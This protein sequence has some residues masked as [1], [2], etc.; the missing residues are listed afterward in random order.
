MP[1][2]SDITPVILTLNEEANLERT[3]ASIAWA[4]RIVIVDSG[5]TD[6]TREIAA[7]DPRVR[8]HVRAFDTHA[9][10]WTF[11]T[12][13]PDINTTWILALDADYQTP[14]ET[15]AEIDAE[16]DRHEVAGYRLSFRYAVL[17]KIIGSGIY[18]PVTCLFRKGR[19]AYVQDGHT[20][21][22]EVQGEVR[23]LKS[24][25][26]HD[27]QKSF[28]RWAASQARYAS[29]ESAKLSEGNGG[30]KAWIRTHTPFAAFAI[31]LHCLVVRGGLF[32]GVPGWLYAM[33]RT[34]AEGLI[35]AAYLES[36][37]RNRRDRC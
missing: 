4:T 1:K 13:H 31:G 22:L 16:P 15:A 25:L 28:A 24:R 23:P 26:I 35:A 27:D 19:G 30:L 2:L 6:R 37:L 10:Q 3:L 14:K 12:G 5:S 17:G 20:Q 34:A 9:S 7:A 21:R 11:A 18:P 32:E 29:L 33:Q 36:R 8:F